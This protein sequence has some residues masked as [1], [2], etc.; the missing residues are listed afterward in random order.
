MPNYKCLRDCHGINTQGEPQL[1]LMGEFYEIDPLHPC[2]VHFNLPPTLRKQALEAER[3]RREQ[4][5]ISQ[6]IRERA[7]AQGVSVADLAMIAA[8]ESVEASPDTVIDSGESTAS[9]E[10]AG[11]QADTTAPGSAVKTKT[12]ECGR[13]FPPKCNR[14]V[15]CPECGE[16]AEAKAN[17][18]R[19]TRYRKR[20]TSS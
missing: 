10:E 15:R 2:A 4:A 8:V 12:C 17:R 16:E 1:Y 18:E 6:E 19:Q 13:E 7:K 3:E 20:K 5:R 11:E 14:Q 9:P